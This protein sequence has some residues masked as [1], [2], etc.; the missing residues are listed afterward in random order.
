VTTEVSTY[1]VAVLRDYP[2]RLW[3]EQN[4]YFDGLLREANLLLI[5]EES[6]S[7]G[8]AAPRRLVQLAAEL[9]DRFGGLLQTVNDERKAALDQGLDR[10]DSRLPLTEGLPAALDH[11]RVV[12]EETDEFCRRDSLLVLPRSAE[13]VAF[14]SWTGTRAG[15][16][17]PT[18]RRRPRPPARAARRSGPPRRRPAGRRG[19]THAPGSGSCPG[20]HG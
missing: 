15:C 18:C 20:P 4:E 13:L 1:R 17:A 5:G 7:V 19:T 14:G 3:V 8:Q 12:L 2:L 9:R 10:M 6:G 16:A 11:M